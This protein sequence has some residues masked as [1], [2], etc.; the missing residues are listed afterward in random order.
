[1]RKEKKRT[2]RVLMTRGEEKEI[3][4]VTSF[5][6]AHGTSILAVGNYSKYRK[7]TAE[8]ANKTSNF[9][10]LKVTAQVNIYEYE[11]KERETGLFQDSVGKQLV[12]KINT[13]GYRLECCRICS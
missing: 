10:T 11:T 9:E 7:R 6:I 12:R 1:M 5:F 13:S 4:S 2:G 3:I 8:S